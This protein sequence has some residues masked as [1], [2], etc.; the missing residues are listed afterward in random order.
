MDNYWL[1]ALWSVTPTVLIGLIFW[2]IVRSIIRA[3][4]N[5]RAA[6]A[7]LESRERARMGLPPRGRTRGTQ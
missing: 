1:N 5:E 7:D 4:R 6:Y 3:D 2:Y